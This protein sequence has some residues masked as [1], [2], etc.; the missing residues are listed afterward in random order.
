TNSLVERWQAT[1]TGASIPVTLLGKKLRP[2]VRLGTMHRAKGLEFKSVLVPDASDRYLPSPAALQ[3]ADPADRE[4]N[5]AQERR[6]LYVSL[7]RGRDD[8]AVSWVGSPTPFLAEIM[9]A[10]TCTP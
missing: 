7:A 5:L 6:L 10:T 4:D 2:G 1:L 3:T 8:L 9:E